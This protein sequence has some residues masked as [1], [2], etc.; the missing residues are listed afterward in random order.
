MDQGTRQEEITKPKGTW[1]PDGSV[2]CKNK[3]CQR[4]HYLRD[5]EKQGYAV[6][7]PK[8]D[9]SIY[10]VVCPRSGE[11]YDYD[12]EMEVGKPLDATDSSNLENRVARLEHVLGI[13]SKNDEDVVLLKRLA[14]VEA[15][16]TQVAE[17]V[18]G[19]K[20]KNPPI[21]QVS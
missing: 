8:G 13:T 3:N 17:K 9:F 10:R 15:I 21:G 1:E 7:F 12:F 11:Y 5:L 2:V 14:S 6:S 18:L 16:V 4:L 19:T 20:P